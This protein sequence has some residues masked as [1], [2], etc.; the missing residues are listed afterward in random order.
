MDQSPQ[1]KMPGPFRAWCQDRWLQHKDELDCYHLVLDYD[2]QEYFHR[3]KW[4]LRQ[5]FRK[6]GRGSWD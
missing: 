6:E 4:F 1:V 2:M 5:Q 3:H